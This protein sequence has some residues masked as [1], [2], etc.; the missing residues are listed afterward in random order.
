MCVW[1]SV[2]EK[3]FVRESVLYVFKQCLVDLVSVEFYGLVIDVNDAVIFVPTSD[4]TVVGTDVDVS[5]PK[6]NEKTK[7]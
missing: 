7:L 6:R 5:V 4:S 2:T 3:C 1:I